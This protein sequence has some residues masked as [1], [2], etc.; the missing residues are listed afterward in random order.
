MKTA[1][2]LLSLAALGCD[3]AADWPKVEAKAVP[4]QTTGRNLCTP[5]RGPYDLLYTSM[6]S[7]GPATAG[8]MITAS[9][10]VISTTES[11]VDL[12]QLSYTI[13]G[14]GAGMAFDLRVL[15]SPA[16]SPMQFTVQPAS[17]Q[18][19]GGNAYIDFS[20][21]PQIQL[22]PL[23]FGYLDLNIQTSTATPA[24]VYRVRVSYLHGLRTLDRSGASTSLLIGGMDI[25]V[26]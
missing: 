10:A 2:V 22:P 7:T 19:V 12:D 4:V 21:S 17:V 9:M 18:Y 1:Y 11:P 26:N 13:D 6:G 8:Q 20:F 14:D 3:Q 24:G 23:D 5:Q 16:G 25:G 15:V